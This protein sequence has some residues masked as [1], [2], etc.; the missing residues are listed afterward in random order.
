M[1]R[2]GSFLYIDDDEGLARLVE[3]ALTR[4]GHS[5]ALAKDAE[6]GLAILANKRVEV[7]GLDHQLQTGTGMDFLEALKS[8]T[9]APTVVYV[10][11]SE[12]LGTAVAAMRSGAVDFV[13]KSTHEDFILMLVA[14]LEGALE[15]TRLRA[16]RDVAEREMWEAKERAELLLGEVNHRVANSLAIISSLVG[17]QAKAVD[18]EAAKIALAETQTRI[19]A[20]AGVH[21]SLYGSG[22]V[23]S[24]NLQDYLSS[25]LD[26]LGQGS[27]VTIVRDLQPILLKTDSAVS[28]GI[29]ATELVTNAIKYARPIDGPGEV[30][31]SLTQ[32]DSRIEMRV[33][34]DGPGWTGEGTPQGTGL[35]TK[36]IS[37]ISR[38]LGATVTYLANPGT[39]A[40]VS[41]EPLT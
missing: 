5:V 13:P 2:S 40:V 29:L 38:G 14:S 15:I 36:I 39:T 16:A 32:T 35:G 4:R 10:T 23:R 7:V 30:R 17:L 31:V 11:A 37:S 18:H 41:F 27:G 6:A 22:D 26:E 9:D 34:D 19:L 12:E 8:V 24:V 20:I 3:R 25:L 21:K 28:L 1:R 33:S